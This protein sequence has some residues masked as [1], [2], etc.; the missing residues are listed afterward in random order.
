MEIP[1]KIKPFIHQAHWDFI[2]VE[3]LDDEDRK[4]MAELLEAAFADTK[5]EDADEDD[6]KDVV[7]EAKALADDLAVEGEEA[8]DDD[9]VP[10]A[11][12]MAEEVVSEMNG[13]DA[14]EESE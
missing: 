3:R 12:A 11:A 4:L 10:A 2:G 14:G 8:P 1:E 9:E 13:P 6:I 7:R 5:P